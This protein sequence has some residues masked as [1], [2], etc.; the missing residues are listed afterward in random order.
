MK[1]LKIYEEQNTIKEWALVKS[2]L[3]NQIDYFLVHITDIDDEMIK[4]DKFKVL[5]LKDKNEKEDYNYINI[6]KWVVA[7]DNLIFI[8]ESDNEIDCL[9]FFKTLVE[10]DKYNL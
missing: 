4:Y 6:D 5:N 1:H 8:F 7:M 9:N 3:N 2:R 10:I